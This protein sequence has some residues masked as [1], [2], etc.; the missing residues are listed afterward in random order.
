MVAVLLALLTALTY[1]VAN[2]LG[3]LLTRRLPLGGVLVVGQTASLV[4]ALVL[5]ALRGGSTDRTGLL[6]GIAAGILNGAALATFYTAAARGP[7]SIVAPIGSTGAVVPVVVSMLQGERPSV[8]QLVG[9]PVAILGV[10]LAAARAAPHPDADPVAGVGLA[11]FAAAVFGTFLAVFAQASQHGSTRAVLD[12]RAALLACTVL[13]VAA[14]RIPWRIPVREIAAAA[15]PGVLLVTGTAAYGIATTKGLVSIV[16]VLATLSPVITVALAVL[17]L[18]ERLI[19][20][21]RA[22]VAIALAGVVLLAAG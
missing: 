20:R 11:I 15:V 14:A 8:L 1:G 2:Y 19:G 21:Q 9:I 12:S 4:G 17:L 5:F 16:A 18:H 3:P 10:A 22:G 7:I 13:V 6:L